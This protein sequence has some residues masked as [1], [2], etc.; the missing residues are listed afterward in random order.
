MQELG[1]KILNDITWYKK[2]APTNLSCRYF[3]HS[4]ETILWAAKNKISKHCF[5]YQEMKDINENMQMRNLWEFQKEPD[6]LWK[7]AAPLKKEKIFGKHP[8]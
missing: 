3:T 4:A 8:T 6:N 5:N 2:N 1:F 7:I